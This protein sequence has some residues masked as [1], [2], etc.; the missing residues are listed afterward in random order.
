[1]KRSALSMLIAFI[2]ALS[3]R[4]DGI[5]VTVHE[6]RGFGYFLGDT[7]AR[8]VIV[9]VPASVRLRTEALPQPG[10]R[11]YWLDLTDVGVV[12]AAGAR[13]TRI[14]LTYQIFY[15]AL[16]P[17]LVRIPG[18]KLYFDG[19]GI[20]P[21]AE[22]NEAD[23]ST[24]DKSADEK[25][26]AHG[27]ATR[28]VPALDVIV[29]PL[30]EIIPD[31]NND[32][33]AAPLRPDA[34]AGLVGTGRART[35]LLA[36]VLAGLAALTA[37][38]YH[39]AWFPFGARKSRP[40]TRAARQLNALS[41]SDEG[42]VERYRHELLILHRAFDDVYGRRL[43]SSDVGAFLTSRREFAELAGSVNRFFEAS[44]LTFFSGKPSAAQKILPPDSVTGLAYELALH[45]R[46]AA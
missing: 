45:E 36:S 24:G 25:D 43:L 12:G 17:K 27:R 13:Q 2:W 38:A 41:K 46:R 3:A 14:K 9:D 11:D 7:L 19:A 4:A 26:I 18:F 39:Y 16:E 23:K 21:A 33:A 42:D 22:Q 35:G 37:L 28:A 5:N 32:P 29:S 31:K 20:A 10:S 34:V 44:R 6:P 15:S 1:M 40:F 8:E 30:R